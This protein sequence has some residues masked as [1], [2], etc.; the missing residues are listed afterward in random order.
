MD[1]SYHSSKYFNFLDNLTPGY[2]YED[3]ILVEE[4]L[5]E[6]IRLNGYLSPADKDPRLTQEP[7][8]LDKENA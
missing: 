5:R 2:I 3:L 6:S 8:F 7:D 4:E 1:K